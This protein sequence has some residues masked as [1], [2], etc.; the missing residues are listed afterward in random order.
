[1]GI[2]YWIVVGAHR[3]LASRE[4]KFSRGAV[5]ALWSTSSSASSV[6]SSEAGFLECSAFGRAGGSLA[7]LSW[8]SLAR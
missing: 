1:M 4:G 5:T 7:R 8:P 6:A 2:I 3:R